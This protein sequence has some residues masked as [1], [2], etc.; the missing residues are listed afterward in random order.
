[1]NF[2]PQTYSSPSNLKYESA[3]KRTHS[4]KVLPGSTP[5]GPT[6]PPPKIEPKVLSD[7]SGLN[8]S[9]EGGFHHSVDFS[10]RS[11]NPLLFAGIR[12]SLEPSS[13]QKET[14]SHGSNE[15]MLRSD[16]LQGFEMRESQDGP[17]IL[18]KDD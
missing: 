3:A 7:S 12:K 11:T 16:E 6:F 2:K 8:S 15:R 14:S 17:C 18:E 10:H 9:A 1:M 5:L 4:L 13:V